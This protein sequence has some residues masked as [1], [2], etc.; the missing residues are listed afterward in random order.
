MAGRSIWYRLW[1]LDRP[2]LEILTCLKAK[3]TIPLSAANVL[4]DV[5]SCG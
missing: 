1:A 4:L 2:P 5:T 3:S